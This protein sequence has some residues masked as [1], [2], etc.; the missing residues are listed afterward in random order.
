MDAL[1][2]EHEVELSTLVRRLERPLNH[3]SMV[4]AGK[5]TYRCE[6]L[7]RLV[8]IVLNRLR[9][10]CTLNVPVDHAKRV[11]FATMPVYTAKEPMK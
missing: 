4:R 2:R 1:A 5:W 7:Y 6:S 9:C 10:L 3:A 8:L 11:V